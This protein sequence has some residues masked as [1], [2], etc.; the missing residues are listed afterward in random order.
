MIP[1]DIRPWIDADTW[2]AAVTIFMTLGIP[3]LTYLAYVFFGGER[4]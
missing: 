2:G 3:V 4:E 1:S